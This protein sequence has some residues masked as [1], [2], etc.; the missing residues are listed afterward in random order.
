MVSV[1]DILEDFG[2]LTLMDVETDPD[3]VQQVPPG[4]SE[5]EQLL[6]SLL[7]ATELGIED[8]IRQSSL[9]SQTVSTSLMR[10]EMKRLVKQLPGK[11][12]V[13]A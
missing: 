8:I 4:L 3:E 12:F 2:Q 6:L 7:S 10:L 9:P 13:R 5:D 11:L 1:E